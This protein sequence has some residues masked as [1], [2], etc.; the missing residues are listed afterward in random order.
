M[1]FRLWSNNQHR[2][3][4]NDR[5]TF[6]MLLG[7]LSYWAFT[8]TFFFLQVSKD[9]RTNHLG[10]IDAR[11]WV[12]YNWTLALIE[13]SE[14]CVRHI[15][16]GRSRERSLNYLGNASR[17]LLI[18]RRCVFGKQEKTVT[19]FFLLS[20]SREQTV[21]AKI[22]K[23]L[24]LISK[25]CGQ[26]WVMCD[27]LWFTPAAVLLSVISNPKTDFHIIN[28]LRWIYSYLDLF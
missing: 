28:T 15:S 18:L 16:Q 9:L 11:S 24:I 3:M 13:L 2:D 19:I 22:L 5:C 17:S 6:Q 21:H 14:I 12:S 23:A 20:F 26:L 4:R 7:F 25:S 1:T 8:L 27:S 10:E